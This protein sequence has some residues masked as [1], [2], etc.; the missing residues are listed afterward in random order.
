MK[1]RI[2]RAGLFAALLKEAA[3]SIKSMRID[4]GL[5]QSALGKKL[6][7]PVDQATISNWETGKTHIPF[8][9]F[10]YICFVCGVCPEQKTKEIL[11]S[12]SAEDNT[13]K[14]DVSDV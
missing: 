4:A 1:V 3:K 14:K 10:M 6:M 9:A 8:L 13:N 7:P 11:D 2:R 12:Q 5:S